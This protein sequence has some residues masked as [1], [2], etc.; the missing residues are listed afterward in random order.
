MGLSAGDRIL[1]NKL[2]E[3]R[4]SLVTALRKSGLIELFISHIV[5]TYRESA[6]FVFELLQNADDAKAT[7]AKIVLNKEGLHFY[8]NGSVAFS[9]SDCDV[10]RE[11]GVRPGHLNSITTFSLS[12]KPKETDN[13]IGKF[14][15]GF[16]S[17]FQYT[18]TPEVFNTAFSFRIRNFL[19]PELLPD[20]STEILGDYT[21][22][23]KIPFDNPDKDFKEAFDEISEKLKDLD[24]PLLFLHSL[25]QFEW[26]IEGDRKIFNK[27]LVRTIA[28]GP[29]FVWEVLKL[30]S[31]NVLKLT[32]QHSLTT[33]LKQHI[34]AKVSIGFLLDE[35]GKKLAQGNRND[36]W[37]SHA[38]CFFRTQ[39]YTGLPYILHAPFILTPN[40]EGIKEGRIENQQLY[41]FLG[42][43]LV[44]AVD[45][46][47]SEGF[48]TNEFYYN[49]PIEN[50]VKGSFKVLYKKL[51]TK[52]L[53]GPYIPYGE[54][55]H[56]T[57]GNG[58]VCPD[59]D[60]STLLGLEGGKP[61]HLITNN[62]SAVFVF[63]NQRAFPQAVFTFLAKNFAK[64]QIN[65]QWFAAKITPAFLANLSWDWYLKF[66]DFLSV[67]E[68]LTKK[69]SPLT[70]RQFIEVETRDVTDRVFLSPVNEK[71]N[72]HLY[73]RSGGVTS[74]NVVRVALQQHENAM[75]VLK[76]FELRIP[77]VYDDL[78]S[79]VLPKY[80]KEDHTVP[81][82][83]AKDDF[84]NIMSLLRSAS[85]DERAQ[86]LERL[87]LCWWLIACDNKGE[88]TYTCP[89]QNIVYVPFDSL[90]VFFSASPDKHWVDEEFYGN[91]SY[92]AQAADLELSE[93]PY[94]FTRRTQNP[95]TN[96][97]KNAGIQKPVSGRDFVYLDKDLD[98]LE[99][100]LNDPQLDG[101]VYL[102]NHLGS[103]PASVISSRLEYFNYSS[104]VLHGNS[105]IIILLKKSRWV[106]RNDGSIGRPDEVYLDSLHDL[107][108]D[109]A[110]EFLK[111][112]GVTADEEEERL[113]TLDE[114]ERAMI[115]LYKKAKEAGLS[116]GEIEVLVQAKLREKNAKSNNTLDETK[117]TGLAKKWVNKAIDTIP[118][119]PDDQLNHGFRPIPKAINKSASEDL[120]E[121]EDDMIPAVVDKTERSGRVEQERVEELSQ[122]IQLEAARKEN[123]A[124]LEKS[125]MYSFQWFNIL[126]ELEDSHSL[127]DRI[128][129][130]A[131][132]VTFGSAY[133]DSDGTL[134]LAGAPHMPQSIED[135][136]SLQVTFYTEDTQR[137]VEAEAVSPQKDKLKVKL[138]KPGTL[139]GFNL[140]QVTRAVVEVS[141]ADFILTKL[142]SAFRNLNFKNNDSLLRL[143][144]RDINFIFGPPGTGKTS[145]LSWLIGGKNN[146]KLLLGKQEIL[147]FKL[148][149]DSRVLVLAP[150]NK[151]ADVLVE[152]ILSNYNEA[153]DNSYQ[154]WL[155]RFG[156]TK[157]TTILSSPVFVKDRNISRAQF[158]RGVIVT[159]IARY[160]YDFLMV[161]GKEKI[162]LAD[163]PW[164]YVVFDEASMITLASILFTIY[165][166]HSINN[167][168][169]F[170]VGGDPFQIHPVIKYEWPGWSHLTE[171][172]LDDQGNQKKNADGTP[173]E[174]RIDGGN[175]YSMVGLLAENSFISP[176]T[177]P[178]AF[179]VHNLTKQYRSVV[180]I[181][182]LFSR[183]RYGGQLTHD[184]TVGVMTND[185][186][187]QIKEIT[188]NGLGLKALTF[189]H[190]PVKK[191][192]GIFRARS[193]KGSPYQIYSAIFTVEL[194][195]YMNENSRI[196]TARPYR[197]GVICPYKIQ[198]SI[199]G[200][201]VKKACLSNL[202]V[203]TGTVHGFQGDECDMIIAVFNPSTKISRSTR[204]FLN[205]KN[206]INVAISRAR[207]K[208][209]LLLPE[210]ADN[211]LNITD[212]H[213]LKRL[214]SIA[215]RTP[216]ISAD[217]VAYDATS[218]EKLI[219]PAVSI[220]SMCF[221]TAHQNVNIYAETLKKYEIRFDESA[222]DIQIKSNKGSKD[223][224]AIDLAHPKFIS[225]RDVNTPL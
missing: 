123:E 104:K 6:H 2:V 198:E 64:E 72:P 47:K 209:I 80:E 7:R 31:V 192:G 8:H 206:I 211:D 79:T 124:L 4:T 113:S 160:P 3:D 151:A 163:I 55:Q 143:L 120:M 187:K 41:V 215:G 220:E 185:A 140:Q 44:E 144:P 97:L 53:E 30:N 37:H 1:F 39:E 225:E 224:T 178:H 27:S 213:Q 82:D 154:D 165:S 35:E 142:K 50:E 24:N 33:S 158:E 157:S 85:Q 216:S 182:E 219:C 166:S 29:E 110:V 119:Q 100:F 202:E 56:T 101:S 218:I 138:L 223:E 204:S 87:E 66:F 23:Y 146:E 205:K 78:L 18:S 96:I 133:L 129:K 11:P 62:K 90:R 25:R 109:I 162:G 127:E 117:A 38:Y 188:I 170:F 125:E 189:I 73:L 172:A 92:R 134:V 121:E 169:R 194:L 88:R 16:K 217:L 17:I 111:K 9:V 21:T 94:I 183:F 186:H 150:T 95:A 132:R 200:N 136:G 77:N 201:I 164:D 161:E 75:A 214:Q 174:Y 99:P 108:S 149:P 93:G 10:E 203:V 173:L 61:L 91:S 19:I 199:I 48:L 145:Y 57:V 49:F 67:N 106:F 212:L 28:S 181:G 107:Y 51:S 60:L 152:R 84:N 155:V 128:K 32:R 98:G 122:A 184:R 180:P 59:A 70:R 26:N 45:V 65:G 34:K 168:V 81:F 179:T 222:I 156:E 148:N 131:I 102:A 86:I 22:V 221:P 74:R 103:L 171:P 112:L 147:P 190:F 159:T 68:Y 191:Y 46:L 176:E 42:N 208:M 207:D 153:N 196:D 137:T 105:K 116:L 141:S 177:V 63:E 114:G 20:A 69:D 135:V 58:Y 115:E 195:K 175:I 83:E 126:L 13:K 54:D 76:R 130:N 43:L 14:G 15:I 89:A 167:N 12:T 36:N 193:I 40:R 210:S 197:I 5:D 118:D 139:D 52:I 71:G